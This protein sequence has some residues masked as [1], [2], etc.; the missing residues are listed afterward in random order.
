MAV[1]ELTDGEKAELNAQP[2]ILSRLAIGSNLQEMQ[3]AINAGGGGGAF[4]WKLG[5]VSTDVTLSLDDQGVIVQHLGTITLPA[6]A[7]NGTTYFIM[8]PP[9]GTEPVRVSGGGN[10]VQ[11]ISG[12]YVSRRP[13]YVVAQNSGGILFWNILNRTGQPYAKIVDKKSS[14]IKGGKFT[15]GA[16]RTRDLNTLQEDQ[17]GI[18]TSLSSNQ[19]KLAEGQYRIQASAPAYFV[20]RHRAAIYNVTQ[21]SFVLL[22]TSEYSNA[23]TEA[24]QTRSF[25]SGL[26]LSNGS[27][28]FELRHRCGETSPGL[29]GFGVESSFGVDEIYSVVE[30]FGAEFY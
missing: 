15:S 21:S 12:T 3:R 7:P 23:P 5:V 13:L 8:S 10:Q 26:L 20:K 24:P 30:I 29:G 14:G 11:G 16:W 1:R 2:G 4:P 9:S 19:F 6:V 27:D 18:V 28:A 17:Q 22:G 25:A